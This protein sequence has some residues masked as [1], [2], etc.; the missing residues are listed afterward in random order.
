MQAAINGMKVAIRSVIGTSSGSPLT[1]TSGS[2]THTG[3]AREKTS[4]KNFS[5]DLFDDVLVYISV[6]CQISSYADYA[7]SDFKC[8]YFV[9]YV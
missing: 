8:N 7:E 2:I 5:G 6:I 4:R 9:M 1:L 3:I